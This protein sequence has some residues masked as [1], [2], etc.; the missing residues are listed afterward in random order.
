MDT[1]RLNQLLKFL[2]DSPKDS[3]L[4]FA[5]AKEYEGLG[6]QQKALD[7]YLRLTETDP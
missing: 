7:F 5:V 1:T 6:D 3:F 2:E 4:M